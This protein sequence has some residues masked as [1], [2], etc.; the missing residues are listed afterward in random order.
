VAGP[1][2]SV[3]DPSPLDFV[4]LTPVRGFAADNDA[5][6]RFEA[7]EPSFAEVIDGLVEAM[8]VPPT[9]AAFSSGAYCRPPTSSR[10]F[11]VFP[12]ADDDGGPGARG[13]VVAF[14]GL[15]PCSGDFGELLADLRRGGPSIHNIAEHFVHEEGKVP[16][17]LTLREAL[18]EA[19][20]GSAY[21][22]AHLEAYGEEA[23]T[24]VP[25]FVFRHADDVVARTANALRLNLSATAFRAVER[26][27]EQ[28]LGV[29][30]Y[31]YPSLPTRVRDIDYLLRGTAF[32]ER[33]LAILGDVC[34]PGEV[35]QGWITGVVRMLYC[36]FIPGSLASWRTGVCCQPQNACIDG[37]FVDLDSLTRFDE[38]VD[39][40]AVIAALHFSVESLI[41]SVRT[42]V[43]GRSDSAWVER[44]STLVDVHHFREYVLA[45][46]RT[47]VQREAR[48]G[49]K[50]DHRVSTYLVPA[51]D[52]AALVGRLDTSSCRSSAF[53]RQA[54][55]FRQTLPALLRSARRAPPTPSQ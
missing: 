15:E 44:Q 23:H 25:V 21:Q 52:L 17:C 26:E 29:Y 50:L 24:P 7:T 45:L 31:C 39:D 42:L 32:R 16:G 28:G 36:G 35:I 49:L 43:A 18:H 41:D 55:E 33:L 4:T 37:G 19:E 3:A 14:K 20:R 38:L 8:P 13:G 11:Y 2:A 54:Q 6:A 27:L 34:D 9:V 46:V 1:D 51:I 53:N 40:T 5:L 10:C 12:G 22:T 48:P 47:A 30:V